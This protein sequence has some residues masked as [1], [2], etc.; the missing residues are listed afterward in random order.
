LMKRLDPHTKTQ[1]KTKVID[2]AA[3]KSRFDI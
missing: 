3:S 1:K 2:E